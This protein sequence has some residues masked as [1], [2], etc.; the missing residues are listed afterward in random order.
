[1]KYLDGSSF[2]VHVGGSTYAEGWD[3]IFGKRDEP[4]Q[5]AVVRVTIPCRNG[6]HETCTKYR[7]W[8]KVDQACA[9]ECHC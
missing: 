6:R 3:R 9:C 8:L 2:T 1:M 4:P 5:D 7:E